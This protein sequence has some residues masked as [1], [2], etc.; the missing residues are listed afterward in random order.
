MR[1]V[2]QRVK[3][4]EVQV[5]N[6]SVGR[7]GRGLLIFVA[8]HPSDNDAHVVWMASKIL[9]LRMFEDAEGKNN[10]SVGDMGGE[11]LVVSQ[12]TLYGDCRKGTKPSF[13]DSAGPELAE[14]LYL[15]LVETLAKSGLRVAQGQFRAMMEVS[16]TNWGPYTIL[17]DSKKEF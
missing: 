14:K 6:V 2:L 17:L 3:Q 8:I 4:A 5:E 1:C 16:L 11:L 10:L 13:S 7:I 15:R 12:F 9:Q